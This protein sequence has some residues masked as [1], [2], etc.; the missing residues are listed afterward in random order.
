MGIFMHRMLWRYHIL[1]KIDI[2]FFVNKAV[3]L[4]F[5]GGELHNVRS[6]YSSWNT[7]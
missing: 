1:I 4:T 3:D 6:L 2:A 5:R 7:L